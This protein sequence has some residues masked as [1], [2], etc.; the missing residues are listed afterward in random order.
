MRL[1]AALPE[2]CCASNVSLS[3]PLPKS[4]SAAALDLQPPRLQHVGGGDAE[5]GVK[6]GRSEDAAQDFVSVVVDLCRA[7]SSLRRNT[8]FN[9]Q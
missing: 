3:L 9:G 1:Y 5:R 8:A 6:D 4:A 2:T 7:Q